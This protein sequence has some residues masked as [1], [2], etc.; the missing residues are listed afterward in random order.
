[1][2]SLEALSALSLA[3]LTAGAEAIAWPECARPGGGY[4]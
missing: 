4:E 1:M 3:Q 2:C